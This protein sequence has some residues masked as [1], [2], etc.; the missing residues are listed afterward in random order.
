MKPPV[1]VVDLS[2]LA[3]DGSNGGAARFVL[4]LLS[5]LGASGEFRLWLLTRAAAARTAAAAVPHA[6]EVLVLGAP[7]RPREPRLLD[8]VSRRLP[9]DLRPLLPDSRP[10]R[11]RGAEALLSPLQSAVF[12]ERGLPHVAV[13]FDFQ[14]LV[15]P[16]F[17]S[18]AETR[19]R[20]RFRAALGRCG[21]V[22]AISEATRSAAVESVRISPHRLS[23]VPPSGPL[24]R[25]A[26]PADE[27]RSRLRS[28]GLAPG[29]FFLYPASAWPHKNHD[30]L[31]RAL[32]LDPGTNGGLGLVPVF[33]GLDRIGLRDLHVRSQ[34]LGLEGRVRL[35]GVVPDPDVTA[36]MQGARFLVFPSL[37]EGFGLPV[38]EAVRL[39]TPVACSDLPALREVAGEAA[40]FFDPS[41]TEAVGAALRRMTFD[42]SLLDDLR[43]RG[44][45]RARLFPATAP[46]E[47]FAREIRSVL[48]GASPPLVSST[49]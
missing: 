15:F 10:L 23:V 7:G 17:F 4:P 2:Q 39:G 11:R 9:V 35:L 48:R 6:E 34:E 41:S 20:R 22:I 37:F 32:V 47:A 43:R 33:C 1:V 49:G 31:L 5:A 13:A 30:R 28:L 36:L 45:V 14:E 18:R 42:V 8:R 38:L 44:P 19:R 26:L 46:V 29:G 21:R 3:P 16:S 12:E 24:E 40:L 25:K 27:L